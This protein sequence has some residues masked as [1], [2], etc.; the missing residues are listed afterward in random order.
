MD[1]LNDFEE[2]PIWNADDNETMMQSIDLDIVPTTGEFFTDYQNVADAL[3]ILH[4]PSLSNNDDSSADAEKL[5]LRGS[6]LD[7]GTMIALSK[8]IPVSKSLVTIDLYH[9][10]IYREGLE[11]LST[12]LVVSPV[13]H[14]RLEYNPL[15]RAPKRAP[16]K[17]EK[18]ETDD[19]D[20]AKVEA[21]AGGPTEAAAANEEEEE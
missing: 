3:G 15:Q 9:V 10:H 8:A 2:I 17:V 5:R 11:V 6:R 18:S 4:H 21:E 14:L 13:K 20:E 19:A 7:M 16:P 1:D 12:A